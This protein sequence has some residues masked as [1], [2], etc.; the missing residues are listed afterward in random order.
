MDEKKVDVIK[1]GI[2]QAE[3][4]Q[5]KTTHEII[6]PKKYGIIIENIVLGIHFSKHA[7]INKMI[8][9]RFELD[10]YNVDLIIKE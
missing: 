8:E 7:F 9:L 4:L 10:S 6:N 2:H 3:V 5:N 1:A